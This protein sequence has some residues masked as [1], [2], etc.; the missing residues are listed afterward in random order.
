MKRMVLMSMYQ[1]IMAAQETSTETILTLVD[2]ANV[3]AGNAKFVVEKFAETVMPQQFIQRALTKGKP[4]EE[5]CLAVL[6]GLFKDS[7]AERHTD[8]V[9]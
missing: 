3:L 8:V 5:F 4:F 2:A 6:S 9:F 7:K 1:T